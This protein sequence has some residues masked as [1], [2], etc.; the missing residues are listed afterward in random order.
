MSRLIPNPYLST[1]SSCPV[2]DRAGRAERRDLGLGGRDRPGEIRAAIAAA[3]DEHHAAVYRLALRYCGGRAAWA[4]DI[5]QEVFLQ[6]VRHAD[7]LEDLDSLGGWLYR[8]TTRRCLNKLRNERFWGWMTFDWILGGKDEPSVDGEARAESR[9]DLRLA[10]NSL[11]RLPAKEQIVFSMHYLDGKTLEEIG[12][13]LGLSKG[14]VSKVL[15]RAVDG[16]AHE[17]WKVGDD[18]PQ[19]G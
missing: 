15:K 11:R 16:L 12:E 5:T 10:L 18:E 9:E 13:V 17:G 1:L 8:T 4:E 6:L 3:Y 19:H 7:S 2:N 14:Y